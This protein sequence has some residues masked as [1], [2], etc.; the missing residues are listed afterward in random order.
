[1]VETHGPFDRVPVAPMPA[2]WYSCVMDYAAVVE[3]DNSRE[4]SEAGR[5]GL[6]EELA[7]ALQSMPGFVS[8]LLLTAYER[9]R[10]MAVV[11]FDSRQ[12]AEALLAGLPEGREI[13]AGVVVRRTEVLEVTASA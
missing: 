13:R 7:P 10:G 5:R 12:A 1:M 3:V 6:R 8:V 11:V 4:D 2:R 9:G